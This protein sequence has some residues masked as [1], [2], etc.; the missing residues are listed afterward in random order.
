MYGPIGKGP[1][2]QIGILLGGALWPACFFRVNK[3][4]KKTDGWR[5]RQTRTP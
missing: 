2:G 3:F 1:P 5:N 4:N